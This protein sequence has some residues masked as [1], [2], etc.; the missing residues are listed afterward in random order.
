MESKKLY[1]AAPG[2][3]DGDENNIPLEDEDVVDDFDSDG[4]T[5][6]F[7]KGVFDQVP[8]DAN[9]SGTDDDDDDEDAAYL[10]QSDP[11]NE[12]EEPNQLEDLPLDAFDIEPND[13]EED[14][15]EA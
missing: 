12:N 1:S 2:S 6:G 13:A 4:S 5:F 3:F 14:D 11:N 9:E 10:D 15:F 7:A 8:D